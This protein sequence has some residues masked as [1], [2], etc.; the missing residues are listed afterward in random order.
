MPKVELKHKNESFEGLM[1]RWK[2]A[3]EKADV[4]KTLRKYEFYERPGDKKKRAK[5][6]AIKREQ[7]RM[8]EQEW[9]R[10]GI[11]PPKPQKKGRWQDDGEE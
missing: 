6:A 3:V 5:A 9:L 8:Q 4:L 10:L 11:R 7:R 2:K 1:R